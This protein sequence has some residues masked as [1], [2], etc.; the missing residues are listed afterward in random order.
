[1]LLN[2]IMCVWNE[3][4]I[5]YSTVKHAFSQGCANVYFIDN[6]STDNTI[7]EACTAGAQ[8]CCKFSSEEFDEEKKIMYINSAIETINKKTVHDSIWWLIID[9]DEFPDIDG[10]LTLL[11]FLQNLDESYRAIHGFMFNHIP[12]HKP[13][14][15]KNF[16][17]ID[18]MPICSKTSTSKIPLL[19][20]DKDSPHIFS[21][22]GAHSFDVDDQD[23]EILE[24]TINIHHFQYR[25]KNTTKVRLE[26]LTVKRE[27]GKSRIDWMDRYA[28]KYSNS[29]QS[30]YH[31]RLQ[32]IDEFY[33][34]NFLTNNTIDTLDY[35]YKNVIRWYNHNC[36]ETYNVP[37]NYSEKMSL[38]Q[39]MFYMKNYVVALCLYHDSAELAKS[40][41]EKMWSF[42]KVAECF[43]LTGDT[44]GKIILQNILPDCD[45]MQCRHANYILRK[46]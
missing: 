7:R 23:I 36:I 18:F 40:K 14:F 38:A 37:E 45:E 1:M 20:Y 6:G 34:D 22:G 11:E 27:D 46:Y 16:H 19:R 5:I 13:Y 39:H 33:K 2:A 15:L 30:M 43:M 24:D 8:L 44:T 12:T 25:I 3:E 35:D 31:C 17:P 26:Y 4:D 10:K 9:A 32:N 42:L 28:Q 41:T 29:N 21:C